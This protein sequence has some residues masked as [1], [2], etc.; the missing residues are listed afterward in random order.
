MFIVMSPAYDIS[1]SEFDIS[2]HRFH[3]GSSWAAQSSGS[4]RSDACWQHIRT[5]HVA[6]VAMMSPTRNANFCHPLSPFIHLYTI[7]LCNLPSPSA[8]M[9]SVCF[10]FFRIVVEE[11]SITFF[12]FGFASS[13]FPPFSLKVCPPQKAVC[14]TS[15]HVELPHPYSQRSQHS[16]YTKER[17]AKTSTVPECWVIQV[18]RSW[19]RWWVSRWALT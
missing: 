6:N 13:T 2:W 10:G 4:C 19:P 15:F 11:L 16:H 14:F 17:H 3:L 9:H 1:S 5:L 8:K 18:A 12:S 7:S